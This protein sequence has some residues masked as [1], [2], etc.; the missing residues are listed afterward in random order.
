[1]LTQAIREDYSLDLSFLEL[2]GSNATDHNFW[3]TALRYRYEVQACDCE[4][5]Y[6]EGI[7]A[8]GLSMGPL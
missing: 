2:L 6:L 8:F 4:V 5:V 7:N 3:I 1:M